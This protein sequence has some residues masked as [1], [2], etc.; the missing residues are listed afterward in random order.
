MLSDNLVN[1]NDTLDKD[2]I[3]DPAIW[4]AWINGIVLKLPYFVR[5]W[6][7]YPLIQKFV[8]DEILPG[9]YSKNL[10]YEF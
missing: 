1:I 2:V 7:L 8:S 10:S 4:F 5:K 3:I 9:T 6:I